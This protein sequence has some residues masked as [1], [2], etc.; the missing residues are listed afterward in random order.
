MGN[1][2]VGLGID[3]VFHFCSKALDSTRFTLFNWAYFSY[4]SFAF[5]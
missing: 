2:G 3:T 4:N 5:I 1:I